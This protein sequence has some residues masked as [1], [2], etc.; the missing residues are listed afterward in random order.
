MKPFLLVTA[1]GISVA[2]CS[3]A[4]KDA[5]FD[6]VL[7]N[8]SPDEVRREMDS[9]PSRFEKLDDKGQYMSWYFGDDYCV[10]FQDEKVVSKDST[11]A[12]TK[13]ESNGTKYE[14]KS[15]AQCLAPGQVAKSDKERSVEVPGV[16]TVKLPKG[17]AQ[18][19]AGS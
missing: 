2:A 5:R 11:A 7:P 18:P 8:M 19:S 13:A 15:V 12:G 14:E 3:T 17:Q 4:S 16:G 9:G 6:R 1:I 10:L